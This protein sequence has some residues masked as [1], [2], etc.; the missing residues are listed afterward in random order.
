MRSV[1]VIKN[2]L[3]RKT[4]FNRPED[5]SKRSSLHQ[6]ITGNRG[7]KRLRAALAAVLLVS[8][9][10]QAA[11]RELPSDPRD[12][13]EAVRW[14]TLVPL[15]AQ[16]HSSSGEWRLGATLLVDWG[17]A[18]ASERRALGDRLDRTLTPLGR[19]W[20]AARPTETPELWF[21]SEGGRGEG[22]TLNVSRFGV[23]VGAEEPAGRYYALVTL[24]QLLPPRSR[25]AD[26][27][28][29]LAGRITDVP[30]YPWRGLMLDSSRH[31]QSV[32][33]LESVLEL[34]ALHK[35]NRFHWHLTDDQG[36]RLEVPG[37][38]RLTEVGAWRTE[39]DG[40]RSGGFYSAADVRRIV[41]FAQ[42]RRIVVVPEVD[43][44]GHSSAA[45]ASYPELS[46][47]GT[48]REVPLDWGVADGVL[49][50]GRA[51][52]TRFTADVLATL[53][54]LFPGPWIHWGG[55]EVYR[56]P[57]LRNA[58]SQAWMKKVKAAT[59]DQALAAFWNGL[60]RLTLDAGRIPVGW[61]EV[62]LFSPPAGTVIQWW[63]TGPRA[64]AAFLAGRPVIGSWKEASYL[65]YPEL[66]SDGDRAPW[67]PVQTL[68]RIA[69][70]PFWPPGTPKAAQSQL[71]GLEAT[72]WTER[73]S[74]PRLGRKLFPRLALLAELAWRGGPG[75][76]PGWR[77]RLEAHRD[78]LTAWGVG[79]PE[80]VR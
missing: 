20:R 19:R 68:D 2:L 53:V 75:G 15:P 11:A 70:Q 71:L 56:T 23:T 1:N 12:Q 10:F 42:Q 8:G 22:Y 76:A 44:P 64:L 72:V 80:P 65:D 29:V 63:D 16:V 54:D 67:M 5:G 25:S 17:A 45:L 55:D 39:V 69:A 73:A 48:P 66:D 33:T 35:L 27:I 7:G 34:M 57:W 62:A 40:R 14:S 18:E 60:A 43:L 31:F 50:L 32:E 6:F 41:D 77:A 13:A 9:S 61:D 3:A 26:E 58:E 28:R 30:A 36:W 38:P 52:V 79:M 59:A 78:R 74:E 47:L 51:S 46:A 37:W 4:F 24:A 49:A 21:R